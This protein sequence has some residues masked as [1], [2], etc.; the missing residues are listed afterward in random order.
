M[1]HHKILKKMNTY[2][3]WIDDPIRERGGFSIG[4]SEWHGLF[5]KEIYFCWTELA[6][7][8]E[9]TRESCSPSQD[10]G[11]HAI[12]HGPGALRGK[13]IEEVIENIKK[14]MQ[15][16]KD[17]KK[18]KVE[19]KT[20][21]RRLMRTYIRKGLKLVGIYG[22]Q[23]TVTDFSLLKLTITTKVENN[24]NWEH[25]FNKGRRIVW[26]NIDENT[27]EALSKKKSGQGAQSLLYISAEDGITVE[28][29]S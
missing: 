10:I 14:D 24:T 12:V 26:R 11:G 3:V 19:E 17:E 15:Y 2:S 7:Y 4:I 22:L 13:T 1:T 23:L 28:R 9:I 6:N 21:A 8:L 16:A 25:V 29:D 5:S 27:W 18:R 20:E